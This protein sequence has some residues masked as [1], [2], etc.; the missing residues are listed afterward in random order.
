MGLVKFD[1]KDD[2]DFKTLVSHLLEMVKY[3][4]TVIVDR[5]ELQKHHEGQLLSHII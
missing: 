5:W 3:A 4:P 2:G 1:D